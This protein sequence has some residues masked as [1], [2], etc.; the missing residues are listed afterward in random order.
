[1]SELTKRILESGLVDEA[2]AELMEHWGALPEGSADLAKGKSEALAKATKA[3]LT[4]LAEKIG[5]EADTVRRLRETVL[6]LN[7][8]KWPTEVNVFGPDGEVARHVVCVID[9][10]GRFFFRPQDVKKEW[11]VPGFVLRRTE[12][13]KMPEETILEVSELFIG[14][15]VVAIQVSTR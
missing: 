6:D 2:T 13:T 3:T 8:I 11:F 5:S 14:D 1:M 10:M 9:R 15:Q 4:K 7:Q 12:N